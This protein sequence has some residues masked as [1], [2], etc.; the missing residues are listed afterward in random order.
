MQT[1]SF[2]LFGA[3]ILGAKT[4]HID[5]GEDKL[6]INTTFYSS[7]SSFEASAIQ[8]FP[9]S[10]IFLVFLITPPPKFCCSPPPPSHFNCSS[11]SHNYFELLSLH[12]KQ[13]NESLIDVAWKGVFDSLY[14]GIRINGKNSRNH[15]FCLS[16][17]CNIYKT[18]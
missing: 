1:T 6:A 2:S 10:S 5:E 13:G 11:P 16:L 8:I 7:F 3:L 15:L 9:S 18:A 4:V 14:F 12:F 17:Y